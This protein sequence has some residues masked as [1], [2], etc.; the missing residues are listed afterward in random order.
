MQTGTVR[1]DKDSAGPVC[2]CVSSWFSRAGFTLSQL[3]AI[4][5]PPWKVSKSPG[6]GMPEGQMPVSFEVSP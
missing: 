2:V 1:A 3:Q 6:V 4:L 5:A